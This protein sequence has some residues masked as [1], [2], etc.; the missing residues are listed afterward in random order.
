MGMRRAEAPAY[1]MEKAQATIAAA[2]MAA[3]NRR[4]GG[5]RAG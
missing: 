4:L 2:K 1:M 3:C 5:G